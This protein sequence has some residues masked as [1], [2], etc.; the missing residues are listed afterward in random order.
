ME[1]Y[2]TSD[3]I[4]QFVQALYESGKFSY[5]QIDSNQISVKKESGEYIFIKIFDKTSW[6]DLVKEVIR[7]EA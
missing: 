4:G 3:K 1:K 6:D 5:I 7:E 2:I